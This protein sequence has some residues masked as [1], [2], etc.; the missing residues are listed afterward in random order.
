MGVKDLPENKIEK[1]N[2]PPTRLGNRPSS[3]RPSVRDGKRPNY[4]EQYENFK[5]ANEELTEKNTN[6][7]RTP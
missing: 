7:I 5:D 3:E 2:I 4:K 6:Q 1:R